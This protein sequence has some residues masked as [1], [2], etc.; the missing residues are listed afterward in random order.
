MSRTE[1]FA[2][3][4]DLPPLSPDD[5]RAILV[6][7]RRCRDAYVGYLRAE[8]YDAKSKALCGHEVGIANGASWDFAAF[9]H[10][11]IAAALGPA[12]P[13]YY[14][15]EEIDEQ[16]TNFETLDWFLGGRDPKPKQDWDDPDGEI[17]G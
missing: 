11:L 13:P 15:A 16:F 5:E 10:M 12:L 2:L 7:A 4:G 3:Q 9:E 8:V 14:I 6:A 17:T 1:A